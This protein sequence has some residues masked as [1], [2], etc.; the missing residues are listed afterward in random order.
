[1]ELTDEELR[2]RGIRRGR[3]EVQEE[4]RRFTLHTLGSLP[5]GRWIT[6]PLQEFSEAEANALKEG[7]VDLSPSEAEEPDV[8]AR[9]AARHAAMLATAL[10][11]AETAD[12]LGVG[13]SRVRQRLAEGTLYGVKVG[14]E[15]R[16]PAFQFEGGAEVPEAAQVLR[17][18]D[19]SVHPVALLNWFT[20][21]DP[22]LYVEGEERAI[23]PREWLLSGGP[24][25]PLCSLAKD[26]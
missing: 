17:Q 5:T 11:T 4:A 21:P 3:G 15:N 12:L 13:E 6:E 24:P 8:L 7:G 1:M 14:R 25:E 20:L 2:E 9:T 10:T 16:L 19:R 18:I 23:S 26:L 22:D